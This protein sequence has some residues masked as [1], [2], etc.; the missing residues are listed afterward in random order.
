M[1]V[2]DKV[3]VQE[4]KNESRKGGKLD[5]QFRGLYTIAEDLGKG[6]YKLKD[7]NGK[8]LTRAYNCHRL[9]LWLEPNEKPDSSKVGQLT[10]SAVY[11]H[12]SMHTSIELSSFEHQLS[13]SDR[14]EIFM[15][16]C[17]VNHFINYKPIPCRMTR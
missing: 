5:L 2:D 12:T 1:Q 9:K 17:D 4:M 6:R 14:A 13:G 11:W 3:L 10:L 7:G 8:V 16:V 15:H